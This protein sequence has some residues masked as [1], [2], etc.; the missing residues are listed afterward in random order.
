MSAA[1]REGR[2]WQ[3]VGSSVP[4]D[5]LILPRLVPSLWPGSGRAIRRPLLA[6]GG[7]AHLPW[8][9]FWQDGQYLGRERLAEE[10]PSWSDRD[11]EWHALR[12]LR[13]QRAAW[14]RADVKLGMWKRLRVL[15]CEGAMAAERLL[16]RG[17]LWEAQ[18]LL[19][20]G[21]LVVAIPR[22][23]C[24]LATV[25]DKSPELLARFD[26]IVSAQYH[27]GETPPLTPQRFTV[28]DARILDVSPLMSARVAGAEPVVLHS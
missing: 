17:L 19:R 18:D 26:L 7:G 13:Y 1:F 12:N 5:A 23:G 11:V 8:V 4:R 27:G 6:E 15:A 9:A 28:R 22:R 21:R 10:H 16:D 25:A 24:L 3:A 14:R 2:W 20:A